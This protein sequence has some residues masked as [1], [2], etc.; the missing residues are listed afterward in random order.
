MCVCMYTWDILYTSRP[1]VP[2]MSNF[3]FLWLLVCF[4][5]ASIYWIRLTE[6]TR[7]I[8]F[9]FGEKKSWKMNTVSITSC[10]ERLG[11]LCLAF[12]FDFWF[13]L[14]HSNLRS[15]TH[16]FFILQIPV[17]DEWAQ[18]IITDTVDSVFECIED[19]VQRLQHLLFA[20]CF[21]KNWMRAFFLKCGHKCITCM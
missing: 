8:S 2:E 14:N 11:W 5:A 15:E 16:Q 12:C 19:K 7:S 17:E 6:Y 13:E 9:Y 3:L 10:K 4:L 21:K 1:D 18:L 20:V